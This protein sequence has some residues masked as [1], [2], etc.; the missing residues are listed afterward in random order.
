[1]R[2]GIDGGCWTNRRGYGRYLRELVAALARLDAGHEYV[3]F[4]DSGADRNE[5]WPKP[6]EPRFVSTRVE[7]AE[8]ARAD[9]RRSVPDVLRMSLAA[10]RER[11]D[12]F[13]FPSVYSYFPL[14]RPVPTLVG[15][16]DTIAENYPQHAF[17]TR[18]QERFWRAKVWLA[19]RQARRCLTV[20][21]HARRSI[22]RVYGFPS[23]RMDVVYEA[24]ADVFRPT[25]EPREDFILDAGGISPSKNL[26]TLVEA[27]AGLTGG[28]RLTL[29]GDYSGDRFQTCHQELLRQI[30]TLGLESRVE[31]TGYVSDAELASL[32][33]RARLF[34]MPS[35]DEGFGLPAVEAMACGAPVVVSTGNAL[36]EVVGDAGLKAAPDDPAGL[37]AAM[38][39]ILTDGAFAAKLSAKGLE[40]AR[41]F[42][43]DATARGVVAALERT[44]AGS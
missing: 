25:G 34:V 9:G 19:L 12:V 16:H 40:R 30:A 23:E 1:M 38:E 24:A 4:L 15:V 14:L 11:F 7:T 13:F 39:R 42:S 43:W 5:A 18:K 44:R 32:Y 31:F 28:T 33:R 2:I 29:T 21:D 3:V 27:F 20:S 6:F 10:A 37:R 36:E 17:A 22:A 41:H 35:L 26:G 8:A